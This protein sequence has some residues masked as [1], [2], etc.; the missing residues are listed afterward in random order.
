MKK[1]EAKKIISWSILCLIIFQSCHNSGSDNSQLLDTNYYEIPINYAKGFQI[2]RYD[3]YDKISVYNPWQGADNIK[4]EYYLMPENQEIPKEI[5]GKIII[6]TPVKKVICLSTTHVGFLDF[7]NQTSKIV[8]LGGTDYIYNQELI[9]NL[10]N[11][12]II[13]I[14]N[15]QS[16]NLELIIALRPDILFIYG[17]SENITG[18]ISELQKL[19]INVI[20]VSEYLESDPLGKAEWSKFFAVFFQEIELAETKFKIIETEY[21]KLKKI[22]DTIKNKPGTLIN[23]PYKGIWYVPGGNSYFAKIINDAGGNYLWADNKSNETFP[24]NFET[25]F[26]KQS[27]ATYL[28]NPSSANSISEILQIEPRLQNFDCINQKNVYNYN[29]KINSKGGNDF[30]ESGVVEPHIILKDLIKIFHPELLKKH[31]FY[32]YKKI[33]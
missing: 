29:A 4:F 3:K 7:I 27:E 10:K 17:I 23:I 13:D 5:Q 16:L 11:G 2:T 8:G 32:Y 1:N 25:A 18:K 14:G 21:N 24:I 30:W 19:G 31:K 28:L 26:S 12:K 22:T 15:E 9:N 33:K 20:I 6:K